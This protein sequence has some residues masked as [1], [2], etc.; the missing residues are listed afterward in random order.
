MRKHERYL[1]GEFWTKRSALLKLVSKYRCSEC[2]RVFDG[3]NK[4]CVQVHHVDGH[5]ENCFWS[6][7]K[8]L[9]AE[10]HVK[11]H[12]ALRRFHE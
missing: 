1:Y 11:A 4:D 5:R 7:L 8:V 10:C 9:C 12:K 6:N 3:F 2:G